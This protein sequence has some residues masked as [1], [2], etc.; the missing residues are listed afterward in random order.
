MRLSV[1][2]TMMMMV[3]VVV[4]MVTAKPM[5]LLTLVNPLKAKEIYRYSRVCFCEMSLLR[6]GGLAFCKFIL[7]LPLI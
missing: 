7:K 5:W 4:V 1:I 2:R 6:R 3:V